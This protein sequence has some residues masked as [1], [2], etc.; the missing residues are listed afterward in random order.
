MMPKRKLERPATTGRTPEGR[1]SWK[2]AEN[3]VKGNLKWALDFME[4]EEVIELLARASQSNLV[5]EN[6]ISEALLLKKYHELSASKIANK[7]PEDA[8]LGGQ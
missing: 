8:N 6:T 4:A 3:Q 5:E 7:L 2:D 1:Q